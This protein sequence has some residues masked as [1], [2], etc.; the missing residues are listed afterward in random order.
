MLRRR[1]FVL[2]LHR[3]HLVGLGRPRRL[4]RECHDDDEK[5]ESDMILNCVGVDKMC[6]DFFLRGF[7]PPFF[8][9]F[10]PKKRSPHNSTQPSKKKRKRT[11]TRSLDT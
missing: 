8:S 5:D 2:L 10:P 9:I 3:L 7:F 11:H 1:R 6:V 4:S